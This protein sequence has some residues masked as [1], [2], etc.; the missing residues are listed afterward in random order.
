M[1]TAEG[2]CTCSAGN[3]PLGLGPRGVLMQETKTLAA[4]PPPSVHDQVAGHRPE[5]SLLASKVIP[6]R[7]EDLWVESTSV[8]MLLTTTVTFGEGG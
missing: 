6:E 7:D 1:H 4:S 3:P 5:G 2:G 8:P